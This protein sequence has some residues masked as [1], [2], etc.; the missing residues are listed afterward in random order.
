ML[1][2]PSQIIKNN[3][4]ICWYLASDSSEAILKI[5][6]LGIKNNGN[7]YCLNCQLKCLLIIPAFQGELSLG[8]KT[9]EYHPMP[10]KHSLSTQ[11]S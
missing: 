3:L 5:A 6:P 9:N 1:W 7:L 4:T 2:I 8:E 11:L 10:K